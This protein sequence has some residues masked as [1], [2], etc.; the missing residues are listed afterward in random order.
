MSMQCL[1]LSQIENSFT[2]DQISETNIFF[3]LRKPHF[4]TM[5]LKS[6]A[7]QQLSSVEGR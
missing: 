4:L 3:L 5:L 7:M 2:Q 6:E 1:T